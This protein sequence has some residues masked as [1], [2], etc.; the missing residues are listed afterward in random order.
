MSKRNRSIVAALAGI[1]ALFT[2]FG[3]GL[4]LG[5]LPQP[6]NGWR[7]TQSAAHNA[8]EAVNPTTQA[9]G[10]AFS[11]ESGLQPSSDDQ[12][13]Y[14][15]EDLEAQR[16]M[17]WWTRIMGVAAAI[18]IFL[19]GISIWLI[20]T[21]F[22]EAKRA[23]DAAHDANRPWLEIEI[24][25][26][27]NMVV[28]NGAVEIYFEATIHNR[29]RSP[30]TNVIVTAA[31]AVESASNFGRVSSLA[32]N[33][34]KKRLDEMYIIALKEGGAVFPTSMATEDYAVEAT[35]EYVASQRRGIDDFRITLAVA[36]T[37]KFSGK[38]CRTIASYWVLPKHPRSDGSET[39]TINSKT[40][41]FQDIKLMDNLNSEAT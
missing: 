9:A 24:S 14:A 17:A 35:R 7:A 36:V 12:S 3:S 37:Y 16:V 4:Y 31:I 40:I 19:G 13:Y 28:N 5:L 2:A 34:A 30:A 33:L 29:G 25:G 18:G 41:G 39:F 21:T 27:P 38:E 26:T 20:F 15:R 8:P 23:A 6:E 22:R 11:P 10:I 32:A 1:A